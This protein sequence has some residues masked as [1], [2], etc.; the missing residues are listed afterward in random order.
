MVTIPGS[1]DLHLQPFPTSNTNPRSSSPSFPLHHLEHCTDRLIRAILST[2]VPTVQ[3]LLSASSSPHTSLDGDYPHD[4]LLVNKPNARGWS[5]IHYCMA[6]KEPLPE[7][8]DA[9]YFAGADTS[10]FTANEYYTPL[11][12]LAT[13]A[14]IV[15][16]SLHS[17]IVH[18]VRDLRA[19][20]SARDRENETCIHLAAEHGAT[21]DV[22]QALL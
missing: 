1:D 19:P 4:A 12:C 5:P 15:S 18:L 8:L 20:L 21:I 11:H 2:D 9:L 10:L 7:V 16:Y 6:A 17:F 22:L 3:S 14:C 13:R